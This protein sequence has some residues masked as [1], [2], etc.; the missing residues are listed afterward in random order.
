MSSSVPQ[1]EKLFLCVHPTVNEFRTTCVNNGWRIEC[2]RSNYNEPIRRSCETVDT[3]FVI[4]CWRT[5]FWVIVGRS[6]QKISAAF[7]CERKECRRYSLVPNLARL[8]RWNIFVAILWVSNSCHIDLT[9]HEQYL[10]ILHLVNKHLISRS[11]SVRHH[12]D[13][14]RLNTANAL[15][16]TVS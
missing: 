9:N 16:L 10:K 2:Q 11:L 1:G 4:N 5:W 15:P 7:V 3:Q 13:T 8:I 12:A 14:I 6:C